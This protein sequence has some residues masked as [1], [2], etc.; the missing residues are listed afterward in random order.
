MR[1]MEWK[2][3]IHPEVHVLNREIQDRGV[4]IQINQQNR[5]QTSR[6]SS[7]KRWRFPVKFDFLR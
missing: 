1:G 4:G 6:D 3:I 5:E 2:M 7:W